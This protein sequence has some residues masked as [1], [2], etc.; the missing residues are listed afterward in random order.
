MRTNRA[1]SDSRRLRNRLLPG[2]CLVAVCILIVTSLVAGGRDM[3]EPHR[4]SLSVSDPRPVAKAVELLEAK[5]GWVITY[6]DPPYAHDSD[7]VD[8]TES[9]R[10][11][12]FKYRPGTAPRVI[13]PKGGELNFDYEVGGPAAQKPD[14]AAAV[15]QQLLSAYSAGNSGTFRLERSG[16]FLHVI[17]ATSKNVAGELAPDESVLDAV[18]TLPAEGRNGV[19]MVDDICEAVSKATGTRV[20][21]GAMPTGLFI[22]YQG[23]Q[24]AATQKAR[25]VLVNELEGIKEKLGVRLSWQLLYDPGMKMYFLNIHPV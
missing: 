25:D 16:Q 3:Q 5:H 19:R 21:V 18:I 6:E 13:G 23:Q 14:A 12:L 1:S 10:R 17:P 22:Q 9:V 2:L 20:V 7:L 24:G 4:V 11:D 15:V 8:V